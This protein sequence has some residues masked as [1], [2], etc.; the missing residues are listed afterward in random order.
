M[1]DTTTHGIRVGAAGQYLPEH[2]DPGQPQYLYGYTIVVSNVGDR[3][4][5][6]MSRHWII[7]DAHGRRE[8]VRGPG[9]IGQTPRLEPGQAFKYQS[10]CPLR[11]SWGTM[12]GQYQMQYD[13][14]KSFE[15]PIGRFYLRVPAEQ[16]P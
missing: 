10:F 15:V 3:P 16:R 13:D 6:L 5:Q 8:D 2:S 12:E 14:G 4:A 9:V 1:S 11:T 7:I